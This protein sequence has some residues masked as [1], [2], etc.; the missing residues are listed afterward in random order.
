MPETVLPPAV[1]DALQRSFLA[2]LP[3]QIAGRAL[4]RGRLVPLRSGDRIA[5]ASKPGV[6]IVVR[7]LVRAY[8]ASP[9]RSL[10]V[11]YARPGDT[12]G[13]V[14]LFG[15][16][17]EVH[18]QALGASA[19]WALGPRRLRELA[20][21]SAPLACA[22]AEECASLVGDALDEL[23]LATF[24]SVRQR[25]ARHLIDLA[26]GNAHEGGL[27]AVVTQQEIAD[28]TGSVREVVARA[29][30]ELQT[31]GLIAARSEGIAVLDAAALDAEARPPL[32]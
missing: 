25:V 31:A 15:A 27:L 4:D 12:L 6:A 7:G 32:R 16:R 22:I 2:K 30:K 17:V 10:T 28:A 9:R 29:L 18:V 24:G 19:L 1:R 3:A 21:E 13:L 20:T 8:I 26:A 23:S 5:P 14:H 11:R